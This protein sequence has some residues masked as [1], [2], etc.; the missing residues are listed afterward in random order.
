VNQAPPDTIKLQ[1]NTQQLQLS[2]GEKTL[3]LTAELLRVCSPSAE[4]RGHGGDGGKPALAKGQVA[5]ID[6]QLQG[7]YAIKLTFDDGHDSGIYTWQYLR[8]LGE[9]QAHHWQLYQESVERYKAQQLGQESPVTW[10]DAR[11]QT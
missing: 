10:V 8:D 5:I 3:T 11:T 4:I 7:N 2:F 6:V 1:R 9:N